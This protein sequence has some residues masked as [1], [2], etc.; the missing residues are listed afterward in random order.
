MLLCVFRRPR[1]CAPCPA[2]TKKPQD[3]SHGFKKKAVGPAATHGLPS[4]MKL[5]FL[6]G[7]AVGSF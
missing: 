1:R 2:H 4:F 5:D 3:F 6:Y 7:Q